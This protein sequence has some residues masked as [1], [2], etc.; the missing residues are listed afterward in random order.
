MGSKREEYLQCNHCG[1]IHKAEIRCRD[2]D[3]Y[4]RNYCPHCEEVTTHLRCGERQEEIYW[5]YDVV[6]DPRYY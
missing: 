4:I 3:L 5:Y 1:C 6:N 2:G